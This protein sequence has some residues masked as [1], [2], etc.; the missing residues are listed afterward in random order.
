MKNQ[1]IIIGT[2]I[3][4]IA[5]IVGLEFSGAL[6]S[7]YFE[8][9]AAFG[10]WGQDIRVLYADGTNESLNILLNKPMASALA[11]NSKAITGF[12]YTLAVKATGAGYSSAT[13]TLGSYVMTVTIM[14]TVG[15]TVVGTYPFTLISGANTVPF[16]SSYHPIGSVAN[17]PVKT[18]IDS[19]SSPS[20]GMYTIT[21]TP[22]GTVTYQ[23]NPGG[24]VQTTSMPTPVSCQVAYQ[25]TTNTLSIDLQ[26][27]PTSY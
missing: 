7:P 13:V 18:K 25:P 1:I 17:I 21:F 16:D 5:I 27:S 3:V 9:K 2:I 19:L 22:T 10:T 6:T 4:I 8:Q 11:Y 14:L 24:S 26:G 12:D 20:A 23:G 15:N